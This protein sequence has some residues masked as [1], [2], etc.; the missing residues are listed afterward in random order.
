VLERQAVSNNVALIVKGT[1]DGQV[2]GL[3]YNP[4]LNNYRPDTTNTA[5]LG[6]MTRAQL[7]AKISAGDTLTVMGVPPASGQRMGIDRN[8]D[9]ILD[10]D[11]GVPSLAIAKAPPNVLISWPTNAP[12]VL[13][14]AVTLP[15]TNWRADTSRRG[16]SG[17]NFQVTN[18]LSSNALYFRLREL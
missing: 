13:E 4:A 14:R 2:H 18:N 15:S 16:I 9:T 8:L 12:Y 10:G 11:A 3:L 6:V 7:Q 17:L 5:I 1:I